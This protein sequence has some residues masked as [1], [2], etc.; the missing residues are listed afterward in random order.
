MVVLV[1]AQVIFDVWWK[2]SMC[3][4]ER[5]QY[6]HCY[7]DDMFFVHFLIISGRVKVY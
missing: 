2:H 7:A 6:N 1:E 4:E 3:E 5:Q